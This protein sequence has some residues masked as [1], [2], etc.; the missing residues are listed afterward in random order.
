VIYDDTAVHVDALPAP[1]VARS[2]VIEELYDTIVRNRPPLHDGAWGLATMEVCLA[3]LR[4]ANE[5]R[6][7]LLEHQV[8]VPRSITVSP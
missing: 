2:E 3:M 1:Q 8:A 6:E 4:S 5:Q 7:I